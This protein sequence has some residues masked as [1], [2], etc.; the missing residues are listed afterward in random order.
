MEGGREEGKSEGM[1]RE[2]GGRGMM[3]GRER[4]R[5]EGERGGRGRV[6]RKERG[7]RE[8]EGGGERDGME[9]VG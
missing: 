2:E 4:E 6:L 1:M 5:M 7:R 3:V 9:G 8:W